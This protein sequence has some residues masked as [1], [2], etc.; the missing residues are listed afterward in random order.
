MLTEIKQNGIGADPGWFRL[1]DLAD[2]NSPFCGNKAFKNTL[3]VCGISCVYMQMSDTL[4]LLS[5][6]VS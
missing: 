4:V 6:D 2:Q 5:S 3:Y 1:S